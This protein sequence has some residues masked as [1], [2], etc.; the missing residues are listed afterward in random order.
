MI[1][2]LRL[3]HRIARD[4]RLTTHV[5]LTA[6]AFGANKIYYSGQKDSNL[7]NSIK[8]VTK[9]FG[10]PFQIEHKEKAIKLIKEKIKQKYTVI[11][12]TVYG[13]QLKKKLKEIKNK[14]LLIIVGGEKVEPEY[15]NLANHNISIGNQPHSEAAALGIILYQINGPK[16][17]FSNAEIEVIPKEKGKL[18]KELK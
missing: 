6:R 3:N 7:E 8:K 13:I 12:L 5:A 1:Q 15:Y 9:R 16:T 10:G 4:K 14:K 17:K 18:L 2:I 11:H